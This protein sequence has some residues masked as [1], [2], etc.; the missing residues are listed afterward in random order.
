M[1]SP[2]FTLRTTSEVRGSAT[3]SYNT[4]KLT[5]TSIIF[6]RIPT[7]VPI[8]AIGMNIRESQIS[9]ARELRTALQ[10]NPRPS[11]AT[12]ILL[13]T[14]ELSV[15]PTRKASSEARATLGAI[16]KTKSK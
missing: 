12:F 8:K 1:P 2:A 10:P 3:I 6:R 15:L 11:E 5:W 7:G 4:L 13:S 14:K 9:P 16:P